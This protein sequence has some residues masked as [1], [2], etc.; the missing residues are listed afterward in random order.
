[1]DVAGDLLITSNILTG[2]D[3]Y[4]LGS[5]S[6]IRAFGHDVGEKRATAVKF[7]ESGKAILG[8]TTVGEM[9]IWDVSTGR[10]LQTLT[11]AGQI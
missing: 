1:M 11:H 10:K 3:L 6:L 2:F 7:I 5:G 8:G 4:S 9:V